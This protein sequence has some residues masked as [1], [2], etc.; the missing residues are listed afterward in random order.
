MATT[1]S[2]IVNQS[3]SPKKTPVFKSTSYLTEPYIKA[4]QKHFGRRTDTPTVKSRQ[5][6]YVTPFR[7]AQMI[8][9]FTTVKAHSDSY[10]TSNQKLITDDSDIVT[11]QRG[12]LCEQ[13]TRENNKLEPKNLYHILAKI[14]IQKSGGEH[15]SF[16]DN[17]EIPREDIKIQE[18]NL[19]EPT[20]LVQTKIMEDKCDSKDPL[21]IDNNSVIFESKNSQDL[22]VKTKLFELKDFVNNE[23]EGKIDQSNVKICPDDSHT[24]FYHGLQET[25]EY[26]R[27]SPITSLVVID[28]IFRSEGQFL[29]FGLA[30]EIKNQAISDRDNNLNE[31][32]EIKSIFVKKLTDQ[33][34]D[35]FLSSKEN[36]S[37]TEPIFLDHFSIKSDIGITSQNSFILCPDLEIKKNK[38]D[39]SSL[40][41]I[42]NFDKKLLFSFGNVK[43]NKLN[44]T[45]LET[46]NDSP[47]EALRD[48]KSD[49]KAI[50][51]TSKNLGKS[52]T[53]TENKIR[54]RYLF[55][56][57]FL[58]FL[59]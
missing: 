46:I 56:S 31:A 11:I 21:S 27:E 30:K 9:D 48:L 12:K 59:L 49:F 14:S 41:K 37:K 32:P 53:T 13:L 55:E 35:L 8:M 45:T 5:N 4:N 2:N 47:S 10:G 34:K 44:V 17:S 16:L 6:S 7:M 1:S 38:F 29:N 18:K 51:N 39:I 24:S 52:S 58:I 25:N 36:A 28:K 23:D 20:T 42:T 43:S 15:I 26:I 57:K 19:I 40:N 50:E 33:N 3:K 22:A 54:K